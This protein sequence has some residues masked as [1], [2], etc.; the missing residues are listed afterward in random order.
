MPEER[1]QLRARV[2]GRVQ[3]VGY[4]FFAIGA[5]RRLNLSG[6][7]RNLADGSV[8]VVAEG[9]R[10]QLLALVGE[11]RQGPPASR[12]EGVSQQYAEATN[13]LVGFEVR[14]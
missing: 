2:T 8:E 11:L 7:A 14:Y 4:R 9:P 13:E 5:G 10:G 1:Q 12:V 3:G 6:Y